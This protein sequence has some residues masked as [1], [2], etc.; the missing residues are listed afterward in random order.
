[1]EAS[2]GEKA[3]LDELVAH[4]LLLP[5]GVPGVFGRAAAFDDVTDR[6]DRLLTAMG[7]REGAEVL[8]FPPVMS[9]RTLELSDFMKS[10]PQL[11]GAVFSFSGTHA[12][13]MSLLERI[14]AG[15][16]WSSLLSVTDVVL[17][18]AA[19]YPLYPTLTEPLPPGG[20]LFDVMTYVFRHEPSTDP[21]RMQSFR[22]HEHVRVGE[23]DAV[24]SWRDA[25]IERGRDLLRSLGL[26]V[27]ADVA[28]DP[29]FGRGG[30]LLAATQRD[31]RLK[32][33]ML[34]PICSTENP[35]AV[36]SVNY[37]QDF[38]GNAFGLKTSDGAVA[39]T[40]CF[41]FGLERVA[42]GLFKTHGPR[43]EAWP[44]KVRATLWP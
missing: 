38:L 30:K 3:F 35:T 33:E 40:A 24:L 10:F 14:H 8:R 29:F 37:H 9:R 39:H 25:W 18:P 13:H 1:M 21:A 17:I 5:G 27:E 34:M 31:Q 23:P 7:V 44:E 42:L 43:T 36:M 11:P 19:C 41:G 6:F 32:F 4:R 22:Q 16:D 2:A 26:P 28:N 20:R 12:Q 15:E